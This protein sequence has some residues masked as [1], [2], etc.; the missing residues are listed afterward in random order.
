MQIMSSSSREEL[1]MSHGS[2]PIHQQYIAV[3]QGT[4]KYNIRKRL[5][6]TTSQ[7]EEHFLSVEEQ[8]DCLIDQATDPGIL[9]RTW[10]G[11]DAWM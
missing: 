9:G 3:A 11:W 7:P 4:A 1:R 2:K 8:V 10:V 6:D 5:L